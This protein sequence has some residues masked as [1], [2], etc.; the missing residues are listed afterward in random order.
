MLTDKVGMLGDTAAKKAF[1]DA[2]PDRWTQRVIDVD[3]LPRLPTI[4]D[5]VSVGGHDRDVLADLPA[6]QGRRDDT[7][8]ATVVGSVANHQC[9]RTIDRDQNLKCLLPTERIGIGED[10]LVRLRSQ[11]IRVA[12]SREPGS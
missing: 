2:P 4:D 11:Q 6:M 5:R 1:G 7:A 10:E 3:S 12:Q 9:G 8:P